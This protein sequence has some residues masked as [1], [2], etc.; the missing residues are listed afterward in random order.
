MMSLKPTTQYVFDCPVHG[1][2]RTIM[3]G[4]SYDPNNFDRWYAVEIKVENYKHLDREDIWKYLR[5]EIES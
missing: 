1:P 3:C 4:R 2:E 5:Q